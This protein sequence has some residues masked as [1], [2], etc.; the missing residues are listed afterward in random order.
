MKILARVLT[1]GACALAFILF[2][3][4][5]PARAQQAA[6]DGGAARYVG[7]VT[8]RADGQGRAVVVLDEQTDLT[9]LPDGIADRVFLFTAET[10]LPANLNLRLPSATLI[11]REGVLEAVSPVS[12]VRVSLRLSGQAPGAAPRALRHDAGDRH[13]VLED[14][15][16]LVEAAG[17]WGG[18]TPQDLSTDD[19][20]GVVT[21]NGG[22]GPS[23][24]PAGGPGSR[25]CSVSCVL[26]LGGGLLGGSMGVGCTAECNPG[27][28]ACCACLDEVAAPHCY[29]IPDVGLPPLTPVNPGTPR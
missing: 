12:G 22:K 25:T 27:F 23:S 19:W 14:G 17:N 10:P 2:A 3:A 6:H 18:Q 16:G 20:I 13:L 7:D 4:P 11:R 21:P 5:A 15:V 8:V 29:C 26:G 1:A 28:Y 24:C 9:A